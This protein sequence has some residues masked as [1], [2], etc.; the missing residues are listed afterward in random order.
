MKH[1]IRCNTSQNTNIQ[2][3]VV[4]VFRACYVSVGDKACKR[5]EL[6]TLSI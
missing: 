6:W 4:L 5:K 1:V 3:L 2:L